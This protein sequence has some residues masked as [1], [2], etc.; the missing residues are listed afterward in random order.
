[1]SA[2]ASVLGVLGL[3][4]VGF[5]RSTQ[6]LPLKSVALRAGVWGVLGLCACARMRLLFN[7]GNEPKE[8]LYASPEKPNTPNTLNTDSINQL[9]L[10]SFNCVGFVLGWL[11]LCWVHVS[12]EK[13]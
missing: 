11:N 13:Q 4:W 7:A 1:M 12:E 8:N 2:T 3:C 9:I 10:L 5:D 6:C